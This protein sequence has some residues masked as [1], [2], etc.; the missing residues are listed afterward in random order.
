MT[1]EQF[2]NGYWYSVEL[3][4]F[5][6]RIGIPSVSLLRKD[7]LEKSIKHFLRSGKIKVPTKRDLKKTGIKDVEIGL[8]LEL[9]ITNYTNNK[10]TK[11]FIVNEAR[12]IEPNLKERSGV[13]YRL[14]RWREEQFIIS[15]KITYG[16]LVKHYINLNQSEEAFSRIPSGR[17]INFLSDFLNEEKCPTR[18]KAIKAWEQLKKSNTPKTYE[19]WKNIQK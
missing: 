18:T 15:K 13:R 10:E 14:N 17:Y 2:D 3:K 5:A 12:K 7:E 6:K 1:E 9:L 8:S 16:D 4:E 19:A 11:E